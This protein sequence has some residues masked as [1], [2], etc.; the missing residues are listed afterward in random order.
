MGSSRLAKAK[1]PTMF[2]HHQ[3]HLM[4]HPI[5]MGSKNQ[6]MEECERSLPS[7][8]LYGAAPEPRLG[9]LYFCWREPP[10]D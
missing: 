7:L 5:T 8:S 9:N 3:A 6:Q 1:Q 4:A 2:L 10:R